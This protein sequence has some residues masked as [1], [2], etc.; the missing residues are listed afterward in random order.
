[1]IINYKP[2]VKPVVLTT[3]RYID[4]GTVFTG[5]LRTSGAVVDSVFLKIPGHVVDLRNNALYGAGAMAYCE[6]KNFK[7]CPRSILTLEDV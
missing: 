4:P 7:T 2:S 3:A 6:V 5:E 1:M